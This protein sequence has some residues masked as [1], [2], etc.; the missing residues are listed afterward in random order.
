M[1]IILLIIS[2]SLIEFTIVCM[3]ILGWL[4]GIF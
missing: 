1:K 3:T 4:F 2:Y